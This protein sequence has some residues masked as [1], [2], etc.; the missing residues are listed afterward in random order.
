M[1]WYIAAGQRLC[2]ARIRDLIAACENGGSG[3]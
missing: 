2:A 3:G 1:R